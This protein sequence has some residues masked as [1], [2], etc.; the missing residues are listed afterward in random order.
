MRRWI[1]ISVVILLVAGAGVTGFWYWQH[2]TTAPTFKTAQVTRGDLMFTI[3]ASGT[4]EPEEV[5]D[6]GAQVQGQILSLGKDPHDSTKSINYCTRVD[7]G[8]ILANI[9]PTL[10]QADVDTAVA[11]KEVADAALLVAKDNLQSAKANLAQFQAKYDQTKAD[12][13]RVGQIRKNTG[14][15]S[16]SEYDQYKASFLTAESALKVGEAAVLQAT[17]GYN[18]AQKSVNQAQ[19]ALKKA[20]QNLS[21]CTIKSPVKGVIVDR[22][23]NVGQT[24]VSSLTAPSLFLL[25]KDLTKMQIWVPVNEADI[26]QIHPGQNVTFTCDAFGTEVFKGVVDKIRLNAQMTQNVITYTVEINTD[27]SSGKLLPYLTANV[28]FQVGEHQNTLLVPNAALRW[29][30]Q[31]SQID[32]TAVPTKGQGKKDKTDKSDKSTTKEQSDRGVLWVQSGRYV[33]PVNVH[34][35]WTDGVNTEVSG[36]DVTEGMEVVVGEVKQGSGGGGTTNPFTP[37]MFQKK[38]N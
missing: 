33:R 6:V 28:S 11:A 5:I 14:A 10:Y 22:R 17:S 7:E 4:V 27:N 25:A 1:I 32:P 12:W 18:Q 3:S 16:D 38:S 23:V 29:M 34:I 2:A 15:V 20:Q 36:K 35:G 24:V 30:P 21:Y 8:T 26:G 19:T 31:Q 9:D 37:Q 13:D